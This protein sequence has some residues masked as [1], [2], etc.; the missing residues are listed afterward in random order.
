ME[1]KNSIRSGTRSKKLDWPLQEVKKDEPLLAPKE[2]PIAVAFTDGKFETT[3]TFNAEQQPGQQRLAK[4]YQFTTKADTA[5]S[6]V[7]PPTTRADV[8]V[9]GP[10]G[11]I[12]RRDDRFGGGSKQ[13]AFLAAKAGI[14]SV[15]VECFHFDAQPFT[16][17]IKELDGSEPLPNNLKLVSEN[18]DVPTLAKAIKLNV[19]DKQFTSAAFSPDNKFFWIAHADSTLSRWENPGFERKGL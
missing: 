11:A 10:D 1:D 13:I 19:Y 14:H 8:R 16:L 5:Y 9:T 6:I 15:F 3:V 18:K 4:E 12:G 7:A 2:P 17:T